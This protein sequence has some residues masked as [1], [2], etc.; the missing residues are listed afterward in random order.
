MVTRAQV[1]I[2]KQN[3]RFAIST[4]SI[5]PIPNTWNLVPKPPNVNVVW[6]MWLFRHTFHV[7]GTL[8]SLALS[9][10]WHIHQLDVKNEFINGDLSE[11]IYVSTTRFCGLSFPT[12]PLLQSI[13][14]SL[15]HEFDMKDLGVLNYFQDSYVLRD[16]ICSQ[17]K[18]AMELLERAYNLS[19]N[20]CQTP[21][22]TES[23]LGPDGVLVDDI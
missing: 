19:S 8:S 15:H 11:T 7:D 4:S 21:H 9:R 14:S 16:S 23:K 2:V 6:S 12:S 22:D 1:G 18:Y 17:K 20:P 13:I 3:P 10:K 5:S